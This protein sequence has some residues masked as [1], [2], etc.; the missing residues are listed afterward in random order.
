MKNIVIEAVF[1]KVLLPYLLFT[2]LAS[3]ATSSQASFFLFLSFKYFSCLSYNTE[4]F[5]PASQNF[6]SLPVVIFAFEKT[7]LAHLTSRVRIM[8][9]TQQT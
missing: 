5:L 8:K 3:F 1:I 7:I 6:C 9:M 2:E 4:N